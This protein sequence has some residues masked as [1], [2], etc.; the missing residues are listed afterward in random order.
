[1]YRNSHVP[2][3][4]LLQHQQ[5]TQLLYNIKTKKLVQSIQLIQIS[6]V[7]YTHLCMHVC[8]R[9]HADAHK[10]SGSLV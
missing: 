2:F 3:P 7:M 1:M 5:L 9:V 10:H 4:Q 6:L 8:N